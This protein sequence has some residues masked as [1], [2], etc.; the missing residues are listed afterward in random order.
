MRRHDWSLSND[1]KELIVILA[2]GAITVSFGI[3]AVVSLVITVKGC[4]P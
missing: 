2:I 4:G 3:V 1:T